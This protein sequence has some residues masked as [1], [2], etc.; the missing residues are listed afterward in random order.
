[1]ATKKAAVKK[2]SSNKKGERTDIKITC[3]VETMDGA[4]HEKEIL[5]ANPLGSITRSQVNNPE[6]IY[7]IFTQGL[8]NQL[9]IN[10]VKS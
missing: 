2:A 7:N 3:M 1:M 4:V 6:H 10:H 5:I 9:G 8:I